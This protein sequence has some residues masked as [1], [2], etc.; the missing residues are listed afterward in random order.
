MTHD[1]NASAGVG[2]GMG[3]R[4]GQINVTVEV[5]GKRLDSDEILVRNGLAHMGWYRL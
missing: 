1:S 5:G 4:G 2:G 3:A